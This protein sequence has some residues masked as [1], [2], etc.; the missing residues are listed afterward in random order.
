MKPRIVSLFLVILFCLSAAAGCGK[1]EKKQETVDE[2]TAEEKS[3]YDILTEALERTNKE[4]SM[5][6]HGGTSYDPRH[7]G[8]A[9][10]CEGSFTQNESGQFIGTVTSTDG[11]MCYYEHNKRY[12][13]SITHLANSRLTHLEKPCDIASACIEEWVIPALGFENFKEFATAMDKEADEITVEDGKT[14]IL[15]K[16]SYFGYC[17]LIMGDEYERWYNQ[18][19]KTQ[20]SELKLSN[21]EIKITLD[22]E[23]RFSEFSFILKTKQLTATTSFSLYDY[24]SKPSVT[25][26][27][28]KNEVG[29]DY[30]RIE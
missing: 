25:A 11:S 28:W 12:Y 29:V 10:G 8:T 19:S 4:S 20:Q 3:T 9:E 6:F 7:L 2:P 30:G 15:Y 1:E 18:L 21:T 14:V 27:D 24:G 16:S 23:G 5:Q 13:K 26:P 22:E 17:R